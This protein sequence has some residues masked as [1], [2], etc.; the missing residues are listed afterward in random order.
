MERWFDNFCSW[1]PI[2]Q[3]IFILIVLSGLFKLVTIL[4]G[5]KEDL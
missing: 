5:K 3:A 4:C 1:N 2:G